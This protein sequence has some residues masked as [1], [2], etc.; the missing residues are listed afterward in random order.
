MF[1]SFFTWLE[2]GML[3]STI[4]KTPVYVLITK[5]GASTFLKG[6]LMSLFK[7]VS[8]FLTTYGGIR[9]SVTPFLI[10][11]GESLGFGF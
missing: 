2:V 10:G 11:T 7:V 4:M 8:G 9:F 5:S 6:L 1:I 3:A